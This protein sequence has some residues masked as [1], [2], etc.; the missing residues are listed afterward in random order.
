MIGWAQGGMTMSTYYNATTGEYEN[1]EN[2]IIEELERLDRLVIV[3]E[4][5]EEEEET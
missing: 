5:D 2:R 3:P 1:L 4:E